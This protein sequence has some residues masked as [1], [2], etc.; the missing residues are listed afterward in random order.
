[1]VNKINKFYFMEIR[2]MVFYNFKIENFFYVDVIWNDIFIDYI[3]DVK[4]LKKLKLE[5]MRID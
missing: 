1:M 4:E 2:K 3:S 5:I